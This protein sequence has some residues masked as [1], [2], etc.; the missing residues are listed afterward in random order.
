[1]VANAASRTCSSRARK[2]RV[3]DGG[4]NCVGEAIR[5]TFQHFACP[6]KPVSPAGGGHAYRQA[7]PVGV[8][9]SDSSD[10]GRDHLL[11]VTLRRVIWPFLSHAVTPTNWYVT[12]VTSGTS[13][14]SGSAR[15]IQRRVRAPCERGQ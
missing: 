8:A 13:G 7:V 1:M 15:G 12:Y 9:A 6:A 11:G 5:H 3:P 4:S 2:S 10:L 14:A